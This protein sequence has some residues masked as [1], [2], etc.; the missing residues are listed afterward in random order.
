[1]IPN[2]YNQRTIKIPWKLCLQV[3]IAL[4]A[5]TW[6]NRFDYYSQNIFKH[7]FF[8]QFSYHAWPKRITYWF[9]RFLMLVPSVYEKIKYGK[10]AKMSQ[11][12]LA[13]SS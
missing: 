1:M 3:N 11:A 10:M 12:P 8:L 9:N 13:Y 4:N 2:I 5:E 7:I 6:M